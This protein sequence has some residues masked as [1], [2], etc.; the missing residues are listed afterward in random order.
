MI[1][2]MSILKCL[3]NL[4]KDNSDQFYSSFSYIK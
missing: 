3:S 2:N 1:I 4:K